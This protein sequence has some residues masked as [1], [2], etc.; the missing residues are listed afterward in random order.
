MGFCSTTTAFDM[1]G[2]KIILEDM[3]QKADVELLYHTIY[4]GCERDGDRI[5]RVYFYAKG[6][7]FEISAKFI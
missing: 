4:T 1:E 5:L 7:A 6:G 3:A 2:M